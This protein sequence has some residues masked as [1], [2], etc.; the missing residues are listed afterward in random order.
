MPR[1]TRL[2]K[3]VRIAADGLAPG[4]SVA[5][6]ARRHGRRR[7]GRSVTGAGLCYE[8][9]MPGE[10]ASALVCREDPLGGRRR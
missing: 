9:L 10:V 1:P 2:A 4:A 7:A 6:V 5:E 8:R 3:K